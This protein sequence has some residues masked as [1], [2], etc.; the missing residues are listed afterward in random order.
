MP[1]AYRAKL[2]IAG[3]EFVQPLDVSM[4][5]R[6]RATREQL[7]AQFLLAQRAFE[8]MIQGMKA[9]GEINALHQKLVAIQSAAA[10]PQDL[11][12][13]AEALDK[14][15]NSVLTGPPQS[16]DQGLRSATLGLTVTLGVVEGADRTPP[17]QAQQ[18][19]T[20]SARTLKARLADW[21]ALKAGSLAK[22]NQQL[23][24]AGLAEIEI[25]E[26]LE[27]AEDSLA[28]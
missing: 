25:A 4:D 2:V 11:R 27:K 15:G 22:L 17:S 21:Q 28:K 9:A 1:G 20:E 26:L 14:A 8:D 10:N 18:L 7:S 13:S 19:Y 24:Q 16:P 23:R 5:P 12:A 6:S 3:R